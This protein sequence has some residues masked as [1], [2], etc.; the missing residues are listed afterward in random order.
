MIKYDVKLN[1]GIEAFGVT[2]KTITANEVTET[3]D[4][5]FLSHHLNLHSHGLIPENIAKTKCLK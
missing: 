4:S 5:N 2:D 3:V 1:N